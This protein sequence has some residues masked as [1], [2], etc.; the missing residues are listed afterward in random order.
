MQ[1]SIAFLPHLVNTY[2][3]QFSSNITMIIITITYYVASIY[4]IIN[5]YECSKSAVNSTRLQNTTKK[6]KAHDALRMLSKFAAEREHDLLSYPATKIVES[7]DEGGS[8]C[9]IFETFYASGCSESGMKMCKFTLSEFRHSFFELQPTI[10][11]NWNVGRGKRSDFKPKDLLFMTLVV[12]KHVG[13]WATI[14]QMFKI[15]GPTL[16]RLISGF[17]AKTQPY[18]IEN[19]VKK[20]DEKYCMNYINEKE[21]LFKNFSYALEAIDVTFQQ[22]KRPSGNMQEGK[23]Y[24][25]GKRKLNG[26][27]VEVAVRPIGIASAFSESFSGIISDLTISYERLHLHMNR[28]KELENEDYDDDFHL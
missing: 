23:V 14:G 2:S 13:S 11:S 25:S 8:E 22:S 4:V 6:Q 7:D 28:L 20:Y 1:S 24:F 5:Y 15:K 3:F 27:K 21:K 19:F 16:L 18:C 10:C 9:P 26:Y 12:S 17:M